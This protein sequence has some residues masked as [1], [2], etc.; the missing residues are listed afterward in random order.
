[1]LSVKFLCPMSLITFEMTGTLVNIVRMK[2]KL[3]DQKNFKP[4]KDELNE[5]MLYILSLSSSEGVR[6]GAEG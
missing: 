3:T 2:K 1:M 4:S 5:A 6:L